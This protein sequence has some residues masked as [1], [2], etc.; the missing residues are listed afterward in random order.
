MPGGCEGLPAAAQDIWKKVYDD[1]IANGDDDQTA[2]QKAW[3][4][5]KKAGYSDSKQ[6]ITFGGHIT[7]LEELPD[8]R[9]KFKSHVVRPGVFNQIRITLELMKKRL[10]D[11]ANVDGALAHMYDAFDARDIG[12]EHTKSYLEDVNGV[13]WITLDGV[14]MMNTAGKD[15]AVLFKK[16]KISLEKGFKGVIAP[17]IGFQ[18]LDIKHGFDDQQDYVMEP[19]DWLPDH[20]AYGRKG[21]QAVPESDM[22]AFQN[23]DD[24]ILRLRR[25]EN[26]SGTNTPPPPAQPP[27]QPPVDMAEERK[28]MEAE[29]RKQLQAEF[30]AE[31]KRQAYAAEVIAEMK[32]KNMPTEGVEK[33]SLDDLR[34]KH[35]EALKATVTSN[36]TDPIDLSGRT[37][38]KKYF[39]VIR[40]GE[41]L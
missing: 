36:A 16:H 1:C 5:V 37:D 13:P 12:I 22:I 17:S 28:K 14:T 38:E 21:H 27:A 26:M 3:G 15:S 30:E 7:C 32:R 39:S 4:A 11:W 18:P 23:A 19:Q 35:I 34:A 2:A 9:V 8:G 6:L 31:N 41:L 25:Q 10:E 29:L 20:V 24:Y 40:A 33:L